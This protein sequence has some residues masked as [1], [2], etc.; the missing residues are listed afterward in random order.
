[1]I[2]HVRRRAP[3]PEALAELC[4]LD[5]PREAPDSSLRDLVCDALGSRGA[6][7]RLD[8]FVVEH[9]P[10]DR[11]RAFRWTPRAARRSLG[12]R[13]ARLV[14]SGESPDLLTAARGE[15]ERQA[16]RARCGLA[17]RGALGAWL[18]QADETV[19]ALCAV[20][21]AT[22][23]AQ[24]LATVAPERSGLVIGISDAWFDVPGA[25]ITLRGRRDAVSVATGEMRR[26]L[27]RLESG[28]PGE[29]ALDG[30]VV[31]A[32]AAALA[33]PSWCP[34]RA[35]VGVWPEAGVTLG[36]PFDDPAATRAVALVL[37]AAGASRKTA[38][39][40]KDPIAA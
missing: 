31:D 27:V 2:P 22:W 15:I 17:R 24:L 32:L 3:S 9:G 28:A 18:A 19:R 11:A 39:L 14:A 26:G 16:D 34:P 20:D 6:V 23:A 35:I 25:R 30:L 1:M 5:S 7:S 13:A 10:A 33:S 40:A 8:A 29:R 4:E 36:V 12:T 38:S 37:E 21:A